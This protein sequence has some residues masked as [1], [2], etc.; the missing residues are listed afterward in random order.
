MAYEIKY[1]GNFTSLLGNRFVIDILEDGFVGDPTIV[2]IVTA[3][4]NYP[5]GD[6]DIYT[7]I[8]SSNLAFQ[9]LCNI[10]LPASSFL[11]E[12]QY[13][14]KVNLY[15][16]EVLAWCG[17]LDSKE[18]KMPLKD[19]NHAVDL[20]AKDGLN[21][22]G[23][24]DLLKLDG[25]PFTS[26]H[27]V[28]E[29]IAAALRPTNLVLDIQT[30]CDLFPVGATG[31]TDKST[32]DFA[33]VHYSTFAV[34]GSKYETCYET[35]EKIMH[36]FK[37]TLFQAEGKWNI[38]N[39]EKRFDND[40]ELNNGLPYDSDGV[41]TT[42]EGARGA[43]SLE[44]GLNKLHKFI[45]NDALITWSEAATKITTNFR[46]DPPVSPIFNSTWEYSTLVPP[47]LEPYADGWQDITSPPATDPQVQ[48]V[49][50]GDTLTRKSLQVNENT[51]TRSPEFLVHE[52]DL[53]SINC[54]VGNRLIISVVLENG[55]NT[56]YLKPDGK[57]QSTPI[58]CADVTEDT[59]NIETVDKAPFSGRVHLDLVWGTRVITNPSFVRNL[60]VQITP[61]FNNE[62]TTNGYYV[63][64]YN[65]N[66]NPVEFTD[67]IYISSSPNHAVK[68]ALLKHNTTGSNDFYEP[69]QFWSRNGV[70]EEVAF[71]DMMSRAYYKMSYRRR[72]RM[73]A[74]LF[75]VVSDGKLLS[76]FSLFVHE[77]YLTKIFSLG[78]ISIN[79]AKD[80][81]EITAIELLDSTIDTEDDTDVKLQGFINK[82]DVEFE[83]PIEMK[84]PLSWR[85]GPTGVII[86]LITKKRWG[87]IR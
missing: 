42:G 18:L 33:L 83:T 69:Q 7:P 81:A 46:Y 73:E 3:S 30:Y 59:F 21:I 8:R 78:S 24:S 10:D 20:V 28:I 60:N 25:D 72:L 29:Y 5:D 15:R 23:A 14:Y 51:A 38:V 63:T 40:G 35:L 77:Y 17:W 16:D 75:R 85:W 74:A 34:S 44:V 66:I 32:F 45:N 12:T 80:T 50:D 47:V 64:R 53:F 9:V 1:K 55:V 67:E 31:L 79:L 22:L 76:P 27:T 26:V 87:K 48:F 86:Q 58:T 54:E 57:W 13:Q 43:N 6:R 39:W 19:V 68:G 70:D 84:K 37:C 61:V 11:T 4:L 62:S 2:K 36:S 82:Q 56:Y 65:P 71:V 52:G 49:Y 41:V